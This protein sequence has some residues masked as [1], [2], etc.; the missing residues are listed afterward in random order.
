MNATQKFYSLF[1]VALALVVCASFAVGYRAGY[2]SSERR[3]HVAGAQAS[4]P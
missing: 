1:F 2:H 3:A 4:S